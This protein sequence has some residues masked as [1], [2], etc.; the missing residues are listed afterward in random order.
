MSSS[1]RTFIKRSIA[2]GLCSATTPGHAAQSPNDKFDLLIMGG[3]AIDP[4]RGIRARADLGVRA[5]QVAAIEA[6]IPA[7]QALRVIDARGKLVTP[8]LIDLHA[9][10]FPHTAA[11]GTPAD[12]LVQRTA[13]TT[14]V[15]V[16]D[17]GAN[18]FAAFRCHVAT[19]R[20]ARV[21]AFVH[22]ANQGF[23]NYPAPEMLNLDHADI[24][25]A[26]RTIAENHDIVIGVKVRQSRSIV[27]GNGLEP[28]KR[29]IAAVERAKTR[30]RAM[31]HIGDTP[32]QLPELLDML[33]PGDI[34][35]HAYSGHGNNLV[36][37]GKLLA[38]ALAAK[39]RGIIIDVGHGGGNFDYAVA[40]AAI[41]QGLQPDVI[42]S[43]IRVARDNALGT[44][45]L[46]WVMSKLLNMGF[47]LE[48]V[49][50]MTT[51]IPAR[52]INRVQ[53]HGTLDLGAPADISILELVEEP[54]RFVDARKS[55]RAGN[56]WLRPVQAIRAGVVVG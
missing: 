37:N 55:V 8:G 32:G 47:T 10:V 31:C 36:Q 39:K 28:L 34:L 56:K 9:H 35:T 49:I 43:D 53:R 13:A 30:G 24:D 46:P 33:R 52:I 29:A 22:I 4:A 14:F 11:I 17:A 25:A 54:V 50:A 2:I 6:E 12:E 1:R 45:Y 21:F 41:E 51:V 15:S 42:S 20:R 16:G 18:N 5:G 7:A 48:H 27:G 44:P 26:A 38:A 19:Q 40:E 23:G 3:E